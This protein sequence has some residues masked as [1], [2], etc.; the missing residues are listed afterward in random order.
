MRGKIEIESVL[1]VLF[2]IAVRR[3]I[4]THVPPGLLLFVPN[5]TRVKHEVVR[6][7]RKGN[8]TEKVKLMKV[9]L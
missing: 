5:R 2:Y 4:F 9:R 6:P 7:R 1:N 3:L 8:S